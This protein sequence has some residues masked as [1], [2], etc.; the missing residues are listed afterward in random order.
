MKHLCINKVCLSVC[1]F[2]SFSLTHMGRPCFL[3][4]R[5]FFFRS[6]CTDILRRL[7]TCQVIPKSQQNE[8]TEQGAGFPTASSNNNTGRNTATLPHQYCNGKGIDSLFEEIAFE[9]YKPGAKSIAFTTSEIRL[10]SWIRCLIERYYKHLNDNCNGYQATWEEPDPA[11]DPDS[12]DKIIIHL[13]ATKDAKAHIFPLAQSSAKENATKTTHRGICV[14]SGH[15]KQNARAFQ[16]L[17]P[18]RNVQLDTVRLSETSIF[19]SWYK[20]SNWAR[21]RKQKYQRGTKDRWCCNWPRRW[22]PWH[23]QDR[24]WCS[25]LNAAET[26]TFDVYNQQITHSENSTKF[27]LECDFTAFLIKQNNC[28]K[29]FRKIWQEMTVKWRT[30]CVN[31]ATQWNQE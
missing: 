21:T 10:D 4:L 1:L 2:L 13:Y 17:Q 29:Y 31:S 6:L 27:S 24:R 22:H 30:D 16:S 28:S 9:L 7:L 3:V 19:N 14:A 18:R 8:K 5:K 25:T 12:C 11:S 20:C 15:R 26:N 23:P